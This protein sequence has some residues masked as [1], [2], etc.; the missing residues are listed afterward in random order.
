[1]ALE[2]WGHRQIEAGRPFEEV[3]HDVLGPDGSSMAFVAVAVDLVLSHWREAAD[4]AWPMVATPELLEFDD[5]RSTR[6]I[7]GVDRILEFEQEPSGWPV[8][9]ADLDARPS[10][11]ARL[12]YSI[13]HY[14]LHA[15]PKQL[16]ALRSSLE[17]ARNEIMQRPAEVEDPING[18]RATA[19]RAVRMTHAEHW[20][21][22]KV[23]LQDGREVEVHQYQCEPEEADRISAQAARADANI[24]HMNVRHRVQTALLD[25]SKS[26]PEIV[27]EGVTWAKAQ[28]QNTEPPPAEGED[29]K[30]DFNKKWDRRT[31]AMTAALA[32]RDYEGADRVDVI[33]WALPLLQASVGSKDEEYHG[34][35]QIEFN[36]AAIAAL[37]LIALYRRDRDVVIRDALLRL[38]SH[39]VV[40]SLGNYLPELAKINPRLPRALVRIVMIGSIHPRRGDSERQNRNRQNAYRKSVEESIAAERR[41]LDGAGGEPAWPE[42]PA[43]LSRR[44]RGI[45]IGGGV[46]EDDEFVQ[47]IPNQY[48][49]EHV[50]GALAGH[51]IRMTVG[52]LPSWVVELATHLMRWSDGANGPHGENELDRDSRPHTWNTHFFEFAGIL[53]VALPHDDVVKLFL[54]PITRFKDEAFHDVMATYLRGFDR[55]VL[56]TDTQKPENPVAVRA[57]LA[58]RIRKG[59]NF[60]RFQQ[61]KT[62]MSETHAGDAMTAMFFLRHR[63]A[64]AGPIVPRDWTGL[65]QV[66]PILT[67]LVVDAPF[68]GYFATLFL[69]LVETSHRA[70][71]LPFVVQA[72]RAWCSAYGVD[73]NFWSEKEIGGRVCAWL[74]QTFAGDPASS[75]V[76]S[77][78]VDDLMRCLD[79][80]VRSGVA[81]AREIEDC[82][83]RMGQS[84]K[85]V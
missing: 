54:D 56:A 44:R 28:R 29:A 22:V 60:R 13:G 59:W 31:V 78:L 82:I 69:N 18:L 11:Q 41:W 8:K 49:D 2:A 66:M 27:A 63:I 20:P 26:T 68:S 64:G 53:S 45:R 74:E 36:M 43:W 80:L 67:E 57:I 77:N 14:V 38:A 21:L 84:Q 4:V 42:L 19:E 46:V 73:T 25:P 12:S 34:N 32:A 72:M 70:L 76:V 37:G 83:V 15:D 5:A 39:T 65:E 51:L 61:E 9:C 35:D 1:M 6:D 17:Q 23:P 47:E 75:A 48:L 16:E 85:S 33:A 55:A 50:L 81:R 40:K 79:I 10:R 52:D 71:L 30:D 58:N 7:A 62:F 3:L 24:R